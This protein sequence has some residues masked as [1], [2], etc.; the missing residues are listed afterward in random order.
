MVSP[1]KTQRNTHTHTHTHTHT[2]THTPN[3]QRN[4]ALEN[5]S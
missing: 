1:N 3:V 2:Q 4:I 5:G